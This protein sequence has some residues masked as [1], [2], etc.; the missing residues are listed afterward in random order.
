MTQ[1]VPGFPLPMGHRFGLSPYDLQVH[2]GSETLQDQHYLRL[3]QR[4][5][6]RYDRDMTVTGAFDGPTQRACIATQRAC[7]LT[8]TADLDEPTWEAVF[9]GRLAPRPVETPAQPK[10]PGWFDD[11][12]K[13]AG[14]VDTPP[15]KQ[16]RA[17]ARAEESNRNK[18]I[19]RNRH[20]GPAPAWY[21]EPDA[22]TK[23]RSILGMPPG[24]YTQELRARVKGL[25]RAGGLAVTGEVDKAT[26]WLID[27]T[28]V[29]AS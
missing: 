20:K 27:E 10:P 14:V 16:S 22:V 5:Y 17:K 25:Q 4:E 3:W 24:R 8:I 7:N 23:I 1:P 13:L 28:T 18:I 19:Y 15:M 29:V 12:G 2:D 21:D 6:A 26:A 11:L 9:D